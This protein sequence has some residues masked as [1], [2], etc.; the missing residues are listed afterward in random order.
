MKTAILSLFLILTT[1]AG[2]RA[3]ELKEIELTDG[4]IITAEVVSLANG[5]YTIRSSSLGT[6]TVQD[7]RVKS[8]RSRGS[9][10]SATSSAAPTSAEISALT[11]KMMSDREIMQMIESLRDDPAFQ[12]ALDDPDIRKAVSSGDTAALMRNPKFLD[13][14]NN[15]TVRDIQKKMQN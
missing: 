9:A 11:E 12:K 5:V 7:S 8:I 3:G 13:I 14:L 2:A 15:A 10:A 4:S 1:A 6:I